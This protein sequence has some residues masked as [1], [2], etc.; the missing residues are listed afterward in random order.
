M[1]I[2][3]KIG[4]DRCRPRR[5]HETA[6]HEREPAGDDEDPGQSQGEGHRQVCDGQEQATEAEDPGGLHDTKKQADA[7]DRDQDEERELDRTRQQRVDRERDRSQREHLE[8]GGVLDGERA[9]EEEQQPELGGQKEHTEES[10]Q[11]AGRGF[12]E[13]LGVVWGGPEAR[14]PL[15]RDQLRV[16]GGQ[17]FRA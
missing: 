8:E 7:G 13:T 6:P 10:L 5:I 1:N 11:P 14:E 12:G 15:H 17:L 9:H 16:V 3:P 2:A 4:P